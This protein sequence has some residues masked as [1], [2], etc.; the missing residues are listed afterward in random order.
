MAPTPKSPQVTD[1]RKEFFRKAAGAGERQ[2]VKRRL[3]RNNGGS[4]E[5]YGRAALLRRSK[6]ISASEMKTQDAKGG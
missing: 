1:T 5:S 3:A 6:K 4:S 2:A